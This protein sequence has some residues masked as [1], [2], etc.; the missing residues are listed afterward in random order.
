VEGLKSGEFLSR[1]EHAGPDVMIFESVV[2]LNPEK[3]R[4]EKGTRIDD[5]VKIEGGT[6]VSIGEYVHI[7]SFASILGGGGA[8]LGPYVGLAQGSRIV[9]G[10]GFPFESA[11]PTP[12]PPGDV[13]ERHRGQVS[14]GAYCLV[15]VNAVVLP[16]VTVGDGGVVASGAVVT[17]DVPEWT[18]V[19]GSPARAIRDRTPYGS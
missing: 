7:A 6:G 5:Y 9:T 8:R 10:G 2:I 3:L 12:P 1:L 15:G 13:Y 17:K 14:L 16:G 18:I 19:A 4:I 11:F